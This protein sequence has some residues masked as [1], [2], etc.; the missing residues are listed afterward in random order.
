M[1]EKSWF[2]GGTSP[3]DASDAP[4]DDDEMSDI[5]RKLFQ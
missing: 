5:F 2:W 1:T 3:G 4:Y